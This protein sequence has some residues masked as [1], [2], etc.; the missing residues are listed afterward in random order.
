ML[1]IM[2][3]KIPERSN[4]KTPVSRRQ[5]ARTIAALTAT[6]PLLACVTKAQTP[7]AKEAP[8]PPNPQPSPAPQVPS[9]VAIAYGEVAAARFGDKLTPEQLARVKRNLEGNIRNA[10]RLRAVKLQNG[11]EPD[12]VFIA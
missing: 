8:A 6:A 2:T 10:E 3:K 4:E 9:P 11:D 5:F 12:F 7:P 1:R